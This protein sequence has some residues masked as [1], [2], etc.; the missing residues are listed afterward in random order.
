MKL[1]KI[2]TKIKRRKYDWKTKRIEG[3]TF[4][5]TLAVIAVTALLTSGTLV[6]ASRLIALAR[7]TSARTQIEYYNSALQTYFIDTGSFPT[8]E[9]G[10]QALW[11]KP[12]S[13]PVPEN[14][15]G[16]YISRDVAKDPW[17]NEYAYFSGD[18]SMPTGT[19]SGLPF[20]IISY[21]ADKTE[22]GEG[23][24]QDIVSWKN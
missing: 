4:V 15:N 23:D 9:Q 6:S 24:A 5:E 10:L 11:S 22:G 13:Y 7:C 1:P 21:G 12:T 18:S 2:Q 20:V 16:P 14:W 17:G 19:P 3:F 8:T